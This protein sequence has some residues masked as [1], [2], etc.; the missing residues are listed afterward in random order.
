MLSY[1]N[2]FCDSNVTIAGENYFQ[3][4]NCCVP[5]IAN[6]GGGHSIYSSIP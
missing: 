5:F 4:C 6:F 3:F 2:L 1:V